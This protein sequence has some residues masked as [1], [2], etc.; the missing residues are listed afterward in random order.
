MS[1]DLFFQLGARKRKFLSVDDSPVLNHESRQSSIENITSPTPKRRRGVAVKAQPKKRTRSSFTEEIPADPDVSFVGETQ[2]SFGSSIPDS[3]FQ[4]HDQLDELVGPT[5]YAGA[6]APA[7][8]IFDKVGKLEGRDVL[9][10]INVEPE[11]EVVSTP[12]KR[13]RASRKP[14]IAR[15]PEKPRTT[16][17]S[18]KVRAEVEI[19]KIEEEEKAEP[20]TAGLIEVA[21]S[22]NTEATGIEIEMETRVSSDVARARAKEAS[23]S[24]AQV[25]DSLK[26]SLQMVETAGLTSG[27]CREAEDLVFGAFIK[28][29]QRGHGDGASD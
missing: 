3:Q 15:S 17:A 9:R 27:Q 18:K 23:S 19:I 20:P 2:L 4:D 26:K 11:L 24:G 28:L 8:G 25:L 1:T 6:R 13:R 10:H 21:D 12:S 14:T 22:M 7:P 5:P 29:R 16:K